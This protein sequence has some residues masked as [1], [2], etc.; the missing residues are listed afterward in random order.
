MT[1][2]GLILLL[3]GGA[4]SALILTDNRP[5]FLVN[6]PFPEWVWFIVTLV[7]AVLMYF[8]RRPAN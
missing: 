8:N 2:V 4:A 5:E 7:G 3:V 1:I 6:M